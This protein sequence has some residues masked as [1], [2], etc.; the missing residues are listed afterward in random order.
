MMDDL[1][2]ML[3]FRRPS[4]SKSEAAFVT[5]FIDALP[6]AVTDGVGNHVV[7]VGGDQSICWTSHF[8]SV[9]RT[10]GKQRL[11]IDSGVISLA[12]EE[13]SN[14]LGADDVAGVWLMRR[15][16]LAGKPGLYI[17]HTGEEIGGIGSTHIAQNNPALMAGVKALISLDR[18][19]YSD[20]I[21]HQAGGRCCSDAFATSL[22]RQLPG[23]SPC[24]Q[25][26][27]TDSANYTGLV[28]ECSNLS[29][30]YFGEHGPG[31]TLD[32]VFLG[33]LLGYLLALNY[34]KLEFSRQ[35]SESDSRRWGAG[36]DY[37]RTDNRLERLCRDHPEVAASLLDAY[38]IGEDDFLD[39]LTNTKGYE[40]VR[41]L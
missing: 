4:G 25:G 22:A 26:I 11:A 39:E 6:G 7:R 8:D 21:T 24:A 20:I 13:T 41:Y 2:Q 18:R 10:G 5:R 36:P 32:T 37:G 27:F 23:F 9:H 16:I 12:P 15:M 30:G 34:S 17:F 28:G 40:N 31:E 19:G 14:C 1:L 33:Y 38:G 29:V 35:P 3:A